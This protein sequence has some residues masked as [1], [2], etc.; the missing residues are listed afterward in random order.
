MIMRNPLQSPGSTS[1]G[2]LLARA[3]MGAMFIMAGSMKFMMKGGL[4]AFVEMSLPASKPFM[5][6]ALGKTYLYTLPFVELLVGALLLV[7]WFS[8][9]AALVASL[10]LLSIIMAVSGFRSPDGQFPPTV[11]MLVITLMLIFTGPGG[12]AVD[13]IRRKAGRG[14]PVAG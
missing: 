6:E 2:L 12:I 9:I 13:G 7:G 5:P 1:F 8:R 3:T 4:G 10:I 11:F 14:L